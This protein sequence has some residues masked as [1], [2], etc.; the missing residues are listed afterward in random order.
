MEYGLI[1]KKL[2]HSHSPWI[3]Q[4]LFGYEYVLKELSEDALKEFFA[5]KS[6]KG[7][8]VTIPYKEKV[9][10]YCDTLSDSAKKIGSV[11]TIVKLADGSLHGDNTDYCGLKYL[12]EKAGIT[13]AGKKV[14]ILGSGGTS[15]TVQALAAD[16][17]AARVTV[18]S[19][20]GNI[21]YDNI[22]ICSD[23]E[24][25]INATPVGMY[26]AN[27]ESLIDLDRFPHCCGVL[28]VIYNPLR[29]NLILQ[30]SAKG[31]PCSGG[32]PMLVAQAARAGESFCGIKPTEEK[33]NEVS[34]SLKK[35]LTNIVFIGMPG[36]GKSSLAALTAEALGREA[37]D[38]DAY[39]VEQDGRTIPQIFSD[40]SEAFFRS[41]EADAVKQ[42][43]KRQGIVIATGG[44]VPL[45][46]DNVRLLRQNGLIIWVTRDL[47]ALSTQGRPLSGDIDRMRQMFSIREK[48]YRGAADV[49][50]YN[51]ST[52]EDAVQKIITQL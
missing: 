47:E 35:R 29:T 30:A 45:S 10:P 4:Q 39:I 40:N 36:S 34:A 27:D 5:Q 17:G 13:F 15:K 3:H 43:S 51:S 12:A 8:N 26:P 11:N 1:G 50:V 44:G 42:L 9:I 23:S 37:C 28:D 49:Q 2:G 41:L 38:T 31:L 18:V 32:L 46:D 48:F 6:F 14:L 22:D 33:I 19:R 21:N 24:I 7:I 52:L 25:I 20:N 16:N